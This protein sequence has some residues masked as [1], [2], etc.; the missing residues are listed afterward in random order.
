M[1]N[2]EGIDFFVILSLMADILQIANYDMNLREASNN[3]L[4][5]ELQKQ[6]QE[7]LEIIKEEIKKLREDLNGK[8]IS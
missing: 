4:M 1:N 3:T 5:Q 6:N 2:S 8:T 7:Y